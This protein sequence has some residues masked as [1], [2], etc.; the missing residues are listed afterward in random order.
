MKGEVNPALTPLTGLPWAEITA[1]QPR[2]DTPRAVSTPENRAK[3]SSRHKKDWLEGFVGF[4][5]D[6]YIYTRTRG[7]QHSASGFRVVSVEDSLTALCGD[8]LEP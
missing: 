8:P 4:V 5:F 6:I 1:H 2:V 7:C 3:M